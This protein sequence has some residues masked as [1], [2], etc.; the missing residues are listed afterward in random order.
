MWAPC[1]KYSKYDLDFSWTLGKDKKLAIKMIWSI[2][3]IV[4]IQFIRNLLIN[5]S[6]HLIIIQ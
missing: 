2:L 6:T 5:P 1:Q 4:V 3:F